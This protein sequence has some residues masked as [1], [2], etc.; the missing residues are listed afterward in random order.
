L[1]SVEVTD[2]GAGVQTI[3]CSNIS[4]V[5]PEDED[6]KLNPTFTIVNALNIK[7]ISKSIET[8]ALLSP[9]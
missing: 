1:S 7:D 5:L 6:L 8:T 3:E 2:K 4:Y 9:S